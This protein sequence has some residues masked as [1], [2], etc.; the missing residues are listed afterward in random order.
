MLEEVKKAP[1]LK[2]RV[3]LFGVTVYGVG[4]VLGAGIYALIGEV[5]GITGNLSWLAFVLAS[6]TGALT[7]LSYA[8]LSA[9][10]PKS[11]AEFVYTEEAFKIRIL[12]FLLGWVII[13]SGILSAATVALGFANYLAALFGVPSIIL[14]VIFAALLIVILSL[15][16][17]IGI[18]AST[19]TNILFTF[20]EAAGLIL[21]II[22]GIPHFGSVNYLELPIGSSFTVVFSAVALIFFAYIGFEDIANIAEEVKNPAKNLP[23]AI[24]YSIIITTVL[25]CLTAISVVSILP[26]SEIADSPAPLNSVTTAVLGPIGGIIMS[27]IALFATANTVLIMMIVTSRMMYGMAR[28][29]ALPEG[30]SKVSPKYRTPALAVLITMILTM[31]PLFLG[32]IS[33]VA[34]A[35]VFGVLITF[36][37]VN[38]SLI[39]LRRKKPDLERPFKLKPNLGWVPIIALLGCIVCFGLLFTFN[40]LIVVIQLI[41]VLCGVVVFYAMKSKIET[42]TS[43]FIQKIDTDKN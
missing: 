4:N 9:M 14:T 16:N 33:I 40:L 42:R 24:I 25:Y 41:I 21:I 23:K 27:F 37:M 34:N 8:E 29:K 20:I 26:Y 15:V 38:L 19:W 3:S 36:F 7:G 10:Y 1:K 17:F 39:A 5:V 28:D 31:I 2:R 11:A 35:T 18:K 30:L 6:I 22:I 32:D 43:R 13:F 12:S